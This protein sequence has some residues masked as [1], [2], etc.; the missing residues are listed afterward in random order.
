MK[1][2][3]IPAMLA[4][5]LMT[6]GSLACDFHGDM[7]GGGAYG[8]KWRTYESDALDALLEAT[9]ST[10]R[11][12][13]DANAQNK[14]KPRPAFS[15][16]AARAVESARARSLKSDTESKVAEESTETN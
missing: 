13:S 6:T 7:F 16:S 4:A 10:K 12:P 9:Y 1:K 8:T 11:A 15:S 3:H 5:G 14:R 2:L